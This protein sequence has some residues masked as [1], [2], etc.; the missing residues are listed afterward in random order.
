MARYFDA[1]LYLANGGKVTPPSYR[2]LSRLSAAWPA[3]QQNQLLER[4]GLGLKL[5]GL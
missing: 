3:G 1:F 4:Q 5:V 2:H